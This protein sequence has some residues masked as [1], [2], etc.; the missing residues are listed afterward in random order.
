VDEI[1]TTATS[2][3]QESLVVQYCKEAESILIG[4]EDYESALRLRKSL[5]ERFQNECGS[6]LVVAAV[7]LHVDNLLR[8]RWG[9][10]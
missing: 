4:A 5:C 8:K 6:S 7:N 1:Y 9:K 10:P 2:M 3:K